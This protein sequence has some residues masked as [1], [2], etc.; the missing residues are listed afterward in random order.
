MVLQ[1]KTNELIQNFE[2][3]YVIRTRKR[4]MKQ[5]AF[6]KV[7]LKALLREPVW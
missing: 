5:L 4:I 3:L 1:G 6:F 7:E 2:Y